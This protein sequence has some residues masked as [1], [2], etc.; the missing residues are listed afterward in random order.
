MQNCTIYFE[1]EFTG[2]VRACLR[3][4][5]WTSVNQQAHAH[6]ELHNV[7]TTHHHST[8]EGRLLVCTHVCNGHSLTDKLKHTV[9]RYTQ[10]KLP[11]GLYEMCVCAYA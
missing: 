4:Y 1:L 10:L 3:L 6:T 11:E 8:T 2:Y 5:G 7:H 9:H